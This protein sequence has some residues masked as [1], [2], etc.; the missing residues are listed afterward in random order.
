M[1]VCA[2]EMRLDP[3]PEPRP[4]SRRDPRPDSPPG[5]RREAR[6]EMRSVVLTGRGA[7]P[8]FA[9]ADASAGA[10]LDFDPRDYI[11]S[12]KALRAMHRGFQLTAAAAVLAMRDAGL[13]A[14]AAGQIAPGSLVAAG[15]A[16]EECGI[17][18]AAGEVN[19]I[20]A[21]LLA[22]LRA[23]PPAN[24]AGQAAGDAAG[25]DGDWSDFAAAAA[26]ELH[27][28]RRLG[29]LTNMA[30]AHIS[31]LFG[32]RG[33]SLTATSGV[34]AGE[35]AL[36]E[37]CRTIAE[38]R[39]EVMICAAADCPESALPAPFGR[40][41]GEAAAALVLENEAAALRRGARPW[42]RLRVEAFAAAGEESPA[43]SDPADA[44]ARAS[45]PNCA[46]LLAVA[47]ASRALRSGERVAGGLRLLP[48]EDSS[49]S[50]A[51]DARPAA[52]EM[53]A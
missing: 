9:A 42:A 32:L 38:G 25:V 13:A 18:V 37:A 36:R 26:H 19:P 31:L 8:D 11:A 3:G 52:E 48:P 43:P 17:A 10:L 12:P 2:A 14:A 40:R 5:A 28:F 50:V 22:A 20:S 51:K 53:R 45:L 23:H 46:A 34:R 47:A 27:P 24:A 21:D 30:A 7:L 44:A 35:Q 15:L 39:A 49:A 6:P 16:A 33:P 41:R 4:L 1:E 29:L